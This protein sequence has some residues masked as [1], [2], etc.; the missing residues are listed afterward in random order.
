MAQ[1]HHIVNT[2]GT[3]GS[4]ALPAGYSLGEYRI[5]QVLGEGGFGITYLATDCN[6]GTRVAIKEYFPQSI[7]ARDDTHAL[8]VRRKTDPRYHQWFAMG[9]DLFV[10]EARTLARFKH[11]NIVRVL[12]FLEANGT[13]YMVMEYEAG[14]SLADY[15]QQHGNRLT[16][17]VLLRIFLPILN[18]LQTIHDGGMLHL[19]IKP[20]NIYLRTDG[21]PLLIDFGSA[22]KITESAGG[23]EMALT[24]DYAAIEQYPSIGKAG[25]YSDIFSLGASMYRCITGKAPFPSTMRFNALKEGKPDPQPKLETLNIGKVSPHVLQ[26][27]EWA[28]EIDPARR[29][30]SARALQ[31]GLMGRGR[32]K[33]ATPAVPDISTAPAEADAPRRKPRALAAVLVILA[34]GTGTA[35]LQRDALTELLLRGPGETA[36]APPQAV[37]PSMRHIGSLAGHERGTNALAFI[38]DNK[39]LVS[40]GEDSRLRMWTVAT[41]EMVRQLEGH[42]APVKAIAQ[43]PNGHLLASGDADGR[44]VLWSTREGKNVGVLKGHRFGVQTLALSADGRWLASSGNDRRMIVWDVTRRAIHKELPNVGNRVLASSFAPNSGL[45]VLAGADGK[46]TVWHAARGEPVAR[47]D[48]ADASLRALAISPDE[49]WVA[50][51]G[52][53]PN[54]QL[55][56]LARR[57]KSRQLQSGVPA[58]QALAFSRR[59]LLFVGSKDQIAVWDLR[60]NQL[61][62]TLSAPMQGIRQLMISADDRVLASASKQGGIDLWALQ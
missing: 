62:D 46:V 45:L 23:K 10:N 52:F 12:R 40:G 18:G 24:P 50:S 26:C 47:L 7:C 60:Q 1:D 56:D 58:V 29:P 9:R 28:L 33:P 21:T 6:L 17:Q 2:T 36:S 59:G 54:V 4:A 3:T 13:A 15:L 11:H 57:G 49:H 51:G 39:V 37:A 22:H 61:V 30:Q 44:I 42:D 53:S 19:D 32:P 41:G 55:W 20:P 8:H 43:T 16:E 38:D 48:G 27:V 25:P 31:E 35:W 34:L 14:Q 5:E